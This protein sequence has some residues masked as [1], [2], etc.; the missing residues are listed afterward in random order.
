M[1]LSRRRPPAVFAAI[2]VVPAVFVE[3]GGFALASSDFSVSQSLVPG[4]MGFVGCSTMA[5]VS[6]AA[7]QDW[8]VEHSG[9]AQSERR[10]C[11][12]DPVY[13]HSSLQGNWYVAPK[14]FGSDPINTG[15][16][17]V[18]ACTSLSPDHTVP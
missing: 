16:S 8:F 11:L 1:S 17:S 4:S 14:E 7:A 18:K 5:A 6:I 10:H 12:V 13:N 9:F 15:V 3:I 2:V